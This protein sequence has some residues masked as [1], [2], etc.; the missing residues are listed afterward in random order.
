MGN[1]M[2]SLNTGVSGLRTNQAA[3]NTSS[4]NLANVSTDGYVRQQ[5]LMTD[6]NYSTI[7]ITTNAIQ[8]LGL[9]TDMAVIRQVRDAFLDKAYRMES[10]R[11]SF[12]ES[13]MESVYEIEDLMGE[14]E[15]EQ[16]QN[17]ISDLWTSLQE[18]AKEPDSIVKRQALLQE[19]T[20][21][22]TRA[23]NISKQLEEYQVSLNTQILEKVDRINKIGKEIEQLNYKICAAECGS[24][25]AN[26]YRDARNILLDELGSLA[27]ITYKENAVGVVTVNLEYQQF[28]TEDH[29]NEL[30]TR[31]IDDTTDMLTVVWGNNE[32]EEVFDIESGYSSSQNTD[33]GSLKGLLIA[34]GGKEAHYTDIPNKNDDKYYK[35]EADG[36]K[37]FLEDKYNADVKVY[38]KKIDS[39]VVMAMQAQFDQLVHGIVTTINDALSPNTDLGE[40]MQNLGMKIQDTDGKYDVAAKINYTV[41]QEINGG[42]YEEEVTITATGKTSKITITDQYGKVTTKTE[43]DSNVTLASIHVWD[44]YNSGV[45]MDQ[46][47]TPRE[48]LF[49]RKNMERYQEAKITCN[50]EE[51]TIWIYN[52]EDPNDMYSLYTLGE[53]EMNEEVLKNP[54]KIPLSGNEHQGLSGAYDTSILEKLLDVWDDPFTTLNPNVLTESNFNDYYTALIGDL[55]S[56]GNIFNSIVESQETTISSIDDQRQ[57]VAGVSSDEELSNLI[58]YQYGYNANSRYITVIDEMLETLITQLG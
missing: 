54:S 31:P 53:V 13:Q 43:T 44:E 38:N 6:S 9:G 46:E 58:M 29:V 56:R 17:T 35:I 14:T 40:L 5:V 4:H 57:Q 26:D 22:I 27:H 3:V 34:R 24:E 28:I 16:F 32:K 48:V 30:S 45:G 47:R 49:E 25:Q 23:N 19:A 50:G 41:K 10:G 21:F 11:L 39:S 55:G 42:I 51:K 33:I 36:T 15:G 2:A 37:T 1:L 18:L 52:E 8:Q 20:T 12:Y 7:K